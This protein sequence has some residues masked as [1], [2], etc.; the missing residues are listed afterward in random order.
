MSLSGSTVGSHRTELSWTDITGQ[1]V[2]EYKVY[3]STT[4]GFTPSPATFVGFSNGPSYEDRN[5][6]PSTTYYYKVSAVDESG[7]EGSVSSQTS[8]ATAAASSSPPAGATSLSASLDGSKDSISLTWTA[9]SSTN[10]LNYKV[11]RSTKST[12]GDDDSYLIATLPPGSTSFQDHMLFDNKTYTYKVAA[13]NV[14]DVCSAPSATASVVVPGNGQVWGFNT[15]GNYEGWNMANDVTSASVNGQLNFTIN[16]IDPYITSDDDLGLRSKRS[17]VV[18]VVMKNDSPATSAQL[19][20][21]SE[22]NPSF[23]GSQLATVPIKAND[24]LYRTYWFDIG[25]MYQYAGILKQLRL[26]LN[27]T[28]GNISID[29]IEVVDGSE[30]MAWEFNAS[31]NTEGWTT[32]Q[33]IDAATVTGGQLEMTF[34]NRTA[35]YL[36][37]LDDLK[38]GARSTQAVKMVAGN[39]T[40]AFQAKLQWITDADSVWNDAKSTV[41]AINPSDTTIRE[42]T[43]PVGGS[44]LW[45]GTIRQLRLQP[46]STDG[47]TAFS[48]TMA[49]DRISVGGS[50]PM[51]NAVPFGLPGDNKVELYWAQNRLD[52]GA[53]VYRSTSYNG[54]YTKL[55]EHPV[56]MHY[57]DATAVNGQTY[58]Y[59]IQ[60][61]NWLGNG[62]VT[63]PT[64]ALTPS[65]S[66]IS[67]RES[68]FAQYKDGVGNWY[69]ETYNGSSYSPMTFVHDQSFND[70]WTGG[71]AKI[72][73]VSQNPA[74]G[75]DAVLKWIAPSTGSIMIIGRPEYV[76]ADRTLGDGTDLKIMKNGTQLWS[77]TLSSS[78]YATESALHSVTVNV[79]AGDF[80]YFHVNAKS[81]AT[82]DSVWWNPQIVY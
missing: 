38:I 78:S 76:G 22:Q 64:G 18:K 61:T 12:Y 13:C 5:L 15:T 56:S 80:I 2:S 47:T 30:Y 28:S 62:I 26:D 10:L 17:H 7:N 68:S 54:A 31:G 36:L 55:N 79:T 57:T 44:S 11:F 20:W 82:Q 27:A 6:T 65:S 67:L 1:G 51:N 43:F 16:G 74:V 23:S 41:I 73:R 59:K 24:S 58:Y 35:P 71:G 8:A 34:T 75:T 72:S 50:L 33:Q 81:N 32:V 63:R 29:S 37:S 39:N 25:Y 21:T 19:F 3:R 48:G 49:I 52:T 4:S 9:S 66:N 40:G 14:N 69:Y 42:Y 53:N 70:Y 46:F 45:S 60:Y 77:A